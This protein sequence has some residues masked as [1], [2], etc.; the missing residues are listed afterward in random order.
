MRT[1]GQTGMT[2]PIVAF[3]NC[4]NAATKKLLHLFTTYMVSNEI[5]K[6]KRAGYI[7]NTS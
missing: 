1:D 7:A 6:D 4:A 3:R 5:Y 2:K